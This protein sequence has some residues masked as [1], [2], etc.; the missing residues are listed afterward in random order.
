MRWMDAEGATT[1]ITRVERTPGSPSW[2][3]DGERIA[4]TMTVRERNTWPIEMPTAP[5]GATWTKPPRII[6]RLDYR[7]DRQ[8][9]T[10]DLYRHLFVVPASGGTARQLTDGNWDHAGAAWTPDGRS[11]LFSSL[12]VDDADY[13]WRESEIYAVDVRQREHPAVDDAARGPIAARSSHPTG[14]R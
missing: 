4:F 9:F 8:G 3:P 2:S 10:N 12:R 14:S 7:Q 11:I 13:E 1:Q 6:E 5:E